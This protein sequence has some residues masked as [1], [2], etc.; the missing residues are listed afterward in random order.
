MLAQL[1]A[2]HAP[3]LRV[4]EIGVDLS[5]ERTVREPRTWRIDTDHLAECL[6]ART[7][8]PMADIETA[9]IQRW[10]ATGPAIVAKSLLEF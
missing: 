5:R 2:A 3:K 9:D 8:H 1:L 6:G 7:G 10:A 4:V